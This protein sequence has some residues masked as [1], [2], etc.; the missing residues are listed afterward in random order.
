[1]DLLELQDHL[2]AF[3]EE[4]DWRQFHTPKNL[5]MALSGEVGELAEVFQWLTTEEAAAVAED[6]GLRSRA[7]EEMADVLAY[8]LLLADALHLDLADALVRKMRV[9][10]ERYPV[11][12]SRGSARKYKD[13]TQGH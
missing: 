11:H 10:E 7:G 5:V 12:L 2:R 6:E 4:R 1:M 3:A 8:L 13:L 9:N